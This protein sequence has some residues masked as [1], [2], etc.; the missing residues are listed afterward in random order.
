MPRFLQLSDME[1]AHSFYGFYC[2]KFHQIPMLISNDFCTS[3]AS[4]DFKSIHVMT[5]LGPKMEISTTAGSG[6]ATSCTLLDRPV[7]FRCLA[8][9]LGVGGSRLEKKGSAGP[10]LRFGKHE[11]RSKAG[12]F[13][14]DAF[15]QVQYDALA[16]TLPDEFLVSTHNSSMF[17]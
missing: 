14:V 6:G 2:A 7:G 17:V 1:L 8:S 16:E 4:I 3:P 11:H 12:T 9:L 5:I 10:D 13:T 15:L